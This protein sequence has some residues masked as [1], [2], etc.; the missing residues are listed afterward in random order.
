MSIRRKLLS[1][2]GVVLC[3]LALAASAMPSTDNPSVGLASVEQERQLTNEILPVGDKPFI[4]INAGETEREN[5]I[6]TMCH[7]QWMGPGAF[8]FPGYFRGLEYYAVYQDP[9]ETGCPLPITYPFQVQNVYWEFFNPNP[10]PLSIKIQPVIYNVDR[11]NPMCPKP[12]EVC[13]YGPVYDVDIPAGPNGFIVRLPIDCCV[14]G[15]YYAGV[16][17]PNFIGPGLFEVVIDNPPAGPRVCASYNN[18]AGGWMD[19]TTPG[20]PGFPGNLRLWSDGLASDMN[21]C[22]PCAKVIEPGVDL[23][24]TPAGT[25]FDNHFTVMPIPADFFNPGSEP[26]SGSICLVGTPLTTSPGGSL[27]R[28]DTIIKRLGSCSLPMVGDECMVPIEIVALSLASCNPITVNYGILPVIEFWDVRVALSSNMPQHQGQ[29]TIRK[30]CCNGGTFDSQLPVVA[31]FIFINTANPS[32]VRVLDLG[33]V[34]PPIM[35]QSTG[36]HWSYDVPPPFD[37]VTCP[38]LVSVDH[39]LFPPSPD[40]LIPPS[41][42]FTPGMR[43]TPCDPQNPNDPYCGGKVLTVEQEMLSQHGVLPPQEITPIEGACCLPDGSC[44]VTDPD[45]CMRMGG[46]YLGNFVPCPIDCAPDT[47]YDT[48]CTAADIVITLNPDDAGCMMP[49]APPLSF[50]HVAGSATVVWRTPGPPYIP[51]QIIETELIEMTLQ[52]THPSLGQMRLRE[53]PG[54]PSRGF[55][56]VINTDPGGN[57]T[58]GDSFFD[59]FVEVDLPA[60]GGT[61]FNPQPIRMHST[62]TELEPLPGT[63]YQMVPQPPSPLLQFPVGP[64]IGFLC[65]A[66]HRIISCQCCV[67]IRGD[68]NNDGRENPNTLDLNFAV[69]RI[70]RGGPLPV[71]ADEGNV[72][73]DTS[74]FNILDLNF[75]V[76]RIFRG[77][78]LP[79]PCPA[80]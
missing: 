33:G 25:S 64:H 7:G 24:T 20:F 76:N 6:A 78:P 54:M 36:G 28:T 14:Y 23:W 52:G 12:G 13:C 21:T 34:F 80:R 37:L 26:F 32:D 79:G 53:S 68:C 42:K 57:L 75:L 71:C 62:L 63:A 73:G 65:E 56:N 39:D 74:P 77:G 16:Y 22:D 67:G 51:G 43:T 41:S 40:V 9:I 70:F 30:N 59:I 60:L 8:F 61:A 4:E 69:N 35:F 1:L 2:G 11:S 19:L 72:N 49:V 5:A 47:I 27:G 17:A 45:C 29:M 15:P 48:L 46:T 44:M 38:G 58:L 10:A 3:V 31:K 50:T 18:K 55:I 66:L